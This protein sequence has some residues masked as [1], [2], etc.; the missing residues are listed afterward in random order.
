VAPHH[1]LSTLIERAIKRSDLPPTKSELRKAL[2]AST[3]AAAFENALDLLVA[4]RK[5]L[6]DRHGM[7]V[8][9]AVDNPKLKALFDSAVEIK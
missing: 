1:S 4:S 7:I 2:P 8:W 5:V 9:V 6:I 3:T